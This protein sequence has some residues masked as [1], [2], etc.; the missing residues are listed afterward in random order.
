MEI[1]GEQEPKWYAMRDLKRPNAKLPAYKQLAEAGFR[2][3][4]PTTSKIV[5]S[6]GRKRR[7]EVPAIQDLLFVYSDRNSLDFTVERT[8]TL[9]YRYVKGGGYREPLVVPTFDMDRFITA[10]SSVKTPHYFQPDEITP[11]MYGSQVR[12]VCDGP[13]NGFEGTLLK[14]KGSGKKRLVVTLPGLLAA[15]IEIGSTDYIELI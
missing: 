9:Q 14:I 3:F 5:E 1:S 15:A 12:M 13:L 10:V 2:I 7:I 8:E 4:T 6:G 11:D